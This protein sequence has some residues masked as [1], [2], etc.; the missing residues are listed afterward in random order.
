MHRRADG[1]REDLCRAS[2]R[3]RAPDEGDLH[4]ARDRFL[5]AHVPLVLP[6][7]GLLAQVAE[8]H[9]GRL[10]IHQDGR[11][12]VQREEIGQDLL[13]KR[14][15]RCLAGEADRGERD[16]HVAG[17]RRRERGERHLV[18]AAVEEDAHRA[19]L[20][21]DEAVGEGAVERA[22]E[23][24]EDAAGVIE[25]GRAR[26]TLAPRGQPHAQPTEDDHEDGGGDAQRK[27]HLD[28]GEPSRPRP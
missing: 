12:A 27:G 5:A 4:R 14:Q 8:A 23:Q 3:A 2:A 15:P 10:G 7:T 28:Q 20:R 21:R 19:L 17:E 22:L 13:A 16:R 26:L 6:G 9:P 25:L 24:D 11:Q 18:R 1:H